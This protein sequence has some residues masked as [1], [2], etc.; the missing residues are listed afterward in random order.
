VSERA[1]RRDEAVAE[2]SATWGGPQTV[3][4][5]VLTIPYRLARIDNAGRSVR[6]TGHAHL[7]PRDLRITASLQPHK[8]R[9]GIFDV[10][11]YHASVRVGGRFAR[12]DVSW[13]RPTPESVEWQDATLSV[14]LS[15]PRGLTQRVT[16]DV[17]GRKAEFTGGVSDVGLFATGIQARLVFTDALQRAEVP[18]VFTLDVNGARD[19]RFL[20]SADET[21]VQLA[22]SWRHPSFWGSPL[23]VHR[24]SDD[25]GFTAQWR[26][27]DFGRP[28]PTR[29]TSGDMSR[30]AL[31]K[32]ARE[33]AFGVSL[34]Q[35]VD[36][37][38]QA[39]R[40]V[41]YAALFIGMTFLLFFVWEISRTTLLHPVQYGLVGFG[42]FVFYLLLV[43]ISEHA[44]FDTAY[45]ISASVTTL[46]I[47]GYGRAVLQ[48]RTQGLS[49]GAALAA[50]YGF[51]YM[52]L[53]LED[54]AL[55]AG[56]LGLFLVL[57]G[58]MYAT[59]R[60]DWYSLRLGTRSGQDPGDDEGRA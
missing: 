55:L 28:Y 10:I 39:E 25:G 45:A 17:D 36:I 50:L 2:V 5:P 26:T 12:P 20:R 15:D 53:R 32:A 6:A 16:L 3:A 37:Y 11:V 30:D 24:P 38:H 35:P 13:I 49:V 27:P 1:A 8:R 31:L 51:L 19:V 21:T 29:W 57:A 42:L 4:G 43:S 23:P 14:G 58:V 9:R 48:G 40:A 33:S 52:L 47:A 41:K 54:Y 44:G 56:S 22:S 46:L 60:M 18:F 7:L 59:R 34:V